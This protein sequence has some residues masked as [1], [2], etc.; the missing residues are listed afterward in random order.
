MTSSN[1][2]NRSEIFDHEY[3]IYSTALSARV[4]GDGRAFSSPSKSAVTLLGGGP[5]NCLLSRN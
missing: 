1:E 4:L 5:S 3:C 2:K